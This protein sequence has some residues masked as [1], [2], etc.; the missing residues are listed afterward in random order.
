MWRF[1][2]IYRKIWLERQV[3]IAAQ[4][5]VHLTV[6]ILWH[7]QAFSTPEQN[8]ALKVLFTP[9]HQ[10]GNASRWATQ[11]RITL[12][13]NVSEK[14]HTMHPYQYSCFLQS[15]LGASCACPRNQM[16]FCSSAR[17]A[18][19]VLH[20]HRLIASAPHQLRS[21]KYAD[22]ASHLFSTLLVVVLVSHVFIGPIVL[23]QPGQVLVLS[24]WQI[25]LVF[26]SK[27]FVSFHSDF[28]AQFCSFINLYFHFVGDSAL[29]K[30]WLVRFFFAY[31]ESFYCE[32]NF[33]GWV[34]SLLSVKKVGVQK[35]R[36][37]Q[38]APDW[39]ESARFQAVCVA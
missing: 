23:F 19:T 21:V 22:L 37:T 6:G 28:L 34:W 12:G 7:F 26:I 17:V 10:P 8:P 29:S 18:Q 31:C 24:G 20:F 5:S 16:Q 4:H 27:D 35:V 1:V 39:W 25:K 36:P 33:A 38:R 2:S 30:Y 3:A 13:G 14:P 11:K 32:Y 15:L 9:A